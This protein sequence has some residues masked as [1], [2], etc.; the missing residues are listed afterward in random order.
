MK[1]KSIAL[2][3]LLMLI[4]VAY[5][6]ADTATKGYIGI[7]DCRVWDG[8]SSTFTRSTSTGGTGTYRKFDW[9][10][11][12]VLQ[13]YGSGTSRTLAT[14]STAAGAVGSSNDVTFWLSPGTWT[15]TGDLTLTDNIALNVPPGAVLS[16]SSSKTLTLEGNITAGAYQIFSGAGS[17]VFGG[18]V[19][20]AYIEWWHGLDIAGATDC[21]SDLQAANDA[22]DNQ[23]GGIIKLLAGDYK[24]SSQVTFDEGVYV[25]GAGINGTLIATDADVSPLKWYESSV[26]N[27]N[28]G[29]LEGV[30]LRG[31]GNAVVLIEVQNIWGFKAHHCRIYGSSAV[32]KGILLKDAAYEADIY[33]CRI[34]DFSSRGVEFATT[35]STYP[36]GSKV[37]LCDFAGDDGA[38][39]VLISGGSNINVVNSRFEFA[40]STGGTGI[41]VNGTADGATITGCLLGGNYA[42][43][44]GSVQINIRGG[45]QHTAIIGNR[46]T[47]TGIYGIT[48]SGSGTGYGTVV[49]NNF[50]IDNGLDV[51]QIDARSY[52]TIADNTFRLIDGGSEGVNQVIKLTASAAQV[53]ILGNVIIGEGSGDMTGDGIDIVDGVSAITIADNQIV[54]MTIG[55]DCNSDQGSHK[56]IIKDNNLSGNGTSISLTALADVEIGGNVGFVTEGSGNGTITSGNTSVDIAHGLAIT[57]SSNAVS[58]QPYGGSTNEPRHVYVSATD[59]TNITIDCDGDP[60]AS[61]LA[62]SWQYDAACE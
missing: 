36:N 55:I 3:A 54:N 57:P 29:G 61:G 23:G 45:A 14:L 37:E 22:L 13:A 19:R 15:I 4:P 16:I 2:I 44:S 18:G 38:T 32:Q 51:V 46:I 24:L 25:E 5:L 34:T 58:V 26:S 47:L 7:N 49:G 28:G 50:E 1:K 9:P 60:G 62:V 40:A 48:F 17:V 53:N 43:G 56:V 10:G 35:A 42:A 6:V 31:N 52:F 59:A 12:D 27:I 41:D 20:E 11:V 21:A 39:A 8:V 30:T 33:G